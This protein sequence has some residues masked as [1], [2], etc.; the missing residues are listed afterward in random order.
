MRYEY[1]CAKCGGS[2]TKPPVSMDGEGASRKMKHGLHGWRCPKD[3]PVAVSR[4]L[5]KSE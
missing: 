3:G 2:V 5:T 4:S 1:K